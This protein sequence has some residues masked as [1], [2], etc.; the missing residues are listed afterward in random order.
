MNKK[1]LYQMARTGKVSVWSIW[2]VK[3][4]ASGSPEVHCEFGQEDGVKTPAVDII[5]SGVNH[6]KS[7]ETTPLEQ[8]ILELE[9]KVVKKKK[10][11]YSEDRDSVNE[12]NTISFSAPFPK[13]LCFYK[14][15]NSISDK[16]LASL[17]KSGKAMY[18]VKRDGLMHIVRKSSAL[19]VEIYSRRMDN[20]TN[21]YPHLVKLFDELLDNG[22]VLLGEILIINDDG[23]DNF[24]NA[25]RI[26]RSDYEDAIEKQTE[27]GN[28]TYYVFDI[29]FKDEECMLTSK[30]YSSRVELLNDYVSKASSE[31]FKCVEI[32]DKPH[33]D[34][35]V[36]IVDRGLEGLV[37]WDGE[38]IIKE[39][40]AFTFNGKSYRPNVIWKSKPKYEDDFIVRFD[41]ENG[42]G[43]YG[44]GRHHGRV[45]SVFIYQ[46]DNDEEVYLGKCGGGLSDELRDFYTNASYPRVWRVEYDSIQPGTGALR[47]P[48]FG[49]DRTE[50]GDKRIDECLMSDKIKNARTGENNE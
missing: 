13:E 37:V 36:E 39:G 29:A 20:V 47:F 35:I 46:I 44:K 40:D 38:A 8:A 43:E 15:K 23:T 24:K 49:A 41:P 6:G 5:S 22:T 17:E 34:A 1:T 3:N 30:S 48:V 4:G 42:I 28:V 7:N 2:V 9:R 27:L 19:G 25:S 45:G 10:E 16:K 50:Q 32:V 26:C 21:N 11:G 18:A 12:T 14:P 33:S 31:F